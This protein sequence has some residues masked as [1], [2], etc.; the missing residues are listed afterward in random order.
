MLLALRHLVFFG[1]ALVA[2]A[3]G[4][5]VVWLLGGYSDGGWAL[6]SPV[7]AALAMAAAGTVM[8]GTYGAALLLVRNPEAVAFVAPLTRRLRRPSQ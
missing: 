3:F 2:A 1:A 6:S 4:A 5:A 7:S 8:A